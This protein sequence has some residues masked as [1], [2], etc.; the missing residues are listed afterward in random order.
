MLYLFLK[1]NKKQQQKWG[2]FHFNISQILFA[3]LVIGP[4]LSD[5]TIN[6]KIFIAGMITVIINL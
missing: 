5:K 6:W 3:M 1:I 4:I 2:D